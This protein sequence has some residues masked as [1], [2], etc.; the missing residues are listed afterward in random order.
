VRGKRLEVGRGAVRRDPQQQGVGVGP[1]V[2]RDGEQLAGA[3]FRAC[4]LLWLNINASASLAS[5]E[6][7]IA[8]ACSLRLAGV[9][10]HRKSRSV[11]QVALLEG[12][13]LAH[14]SSPIE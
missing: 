1:G 11:A 3:L 13:A 10:D 14:K 5:Q 7:Q 12:A 2:E 6:S 4:P 9:H 8:I